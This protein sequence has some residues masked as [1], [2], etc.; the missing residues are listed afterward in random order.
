MAASQNMG[1]PT[2]FKATKSLLDKYICPT[3][4]EKFPFTKIVGNRTKNMRYRFTGW[5]PNENDKKPVY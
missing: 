4:N 5:S 2:T 3:E 1:I